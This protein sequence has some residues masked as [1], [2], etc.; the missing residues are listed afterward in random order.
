MGCPIET[1]RNCCANGG[2]EVDHVTAYRWVQRFTP[3]VADA[4]RFGRHGPGDRWFVAETYVRGNR[5]WWY[6]YRAIDQHGQIVACCTRPVGT[7]T[8]PGDSSDEPW[9]RSRSPRRRSEERRVGKGGRT[10]WG[11]G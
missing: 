9:L 8:R 5:G 6:V 3:L 4:A 2:V 7:P 10:R 11:P 1:S